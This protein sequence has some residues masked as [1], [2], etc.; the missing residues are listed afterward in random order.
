MGL[1][2]DLPITSIDEASLVQETFTLRRDQLN[3]MADMIHTTPEER[4]EM[5]QKAVTLDILLERMVRWNG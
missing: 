1:K 2:I 5:L 3:A 4:T